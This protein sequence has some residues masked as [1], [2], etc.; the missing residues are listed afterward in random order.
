[1]IR[2]SRLASP[3]AQEAAYARRLRGV[4]RRVQL[5][6]QWGLAPLLK[7]W[8]S[9]VDEPTRIDAGPA[10]LSVWVK[11]A[12]GYAAETTVGPAELVRVGRKWHLRL[13][14]QD[15]DIG[16]RA[17]LGRAEGWIR[18]IAAG[19]APPAS[20]RTRAAAR[21]APQPRFP[22]RYNPFTA[23]PIARPIA[24]LSDADLRRLWPGIDPADLRRYAPWATSRSEV[25]RIASYG[26][27]RWTAAQMQRYREGRDIKLSQEQLE[28]YIRD[29]IRAEAVR[30]P[31]DPGPIRFG[32][33]DLVRPPGAFRLRPPPTP[34]LLGADDLP[35]ALPPVPRVMSTEAV[36][37]QLEYLNLTVG[38][39]VNYEALAPVISPTGEQLTRVVTRRLERVLSIDLRAS[40]PMLQRMVD[41]WRDHNVALIESGILGPSADPALRQGLLGDVSRTV[42]EAHHEGLRVERLAYDLRERFRVSDSRAELIA[43]D[44][45]LKLNGQIDRQ[46]QQQAGITEYIW[47]TSRDE[48]VR[49]THAILD[50]TR[51]SWATPPEVAPGRYEHP[52]GDYQCRCSAEAIIPD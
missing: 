5:I 51:Q 45:V 21:G 32:A 20:L 37:R 14:G 34:I 33:P 38:E 35:L 12:T 16:A 47:R 19:N 10:M 25:E 13:P 36:R 15:I 9:G 48:R 18:R 24:D 26:G 28:G 50:G 27:R 4:W 11:T 40:D 29:A 17:E 44:Q 30:Q 39:V 41:T 1:V 52:G 31:Q 8:P 7:V 49:E 42:E 2:P 3:I 43:R 46:R 23:P 6:M 22:P